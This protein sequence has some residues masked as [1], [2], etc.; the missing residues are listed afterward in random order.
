MI[1][2]YHFNSSSNASDIN[3]GILAIKTG[4]Y[5]SATA[6]LKGNGFNATLAKLMNGNPVATTDNTA[7]GNYL[8]AIVN[9]RTGNYDKCIDYLSKAIQM[10]YKLLKTKQQKILN[11]KILKIRLNFKH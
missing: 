10:N 4:D 9:A 11:L 3:K 5:S 2:Q 8:N 6:K 1:K 7:E